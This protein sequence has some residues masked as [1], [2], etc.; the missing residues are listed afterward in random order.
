MMLSLRQIGRIW[1][2]LSFAAG[3]AAA[4]LWALSSAAWQSHLT[5]AYL[6]GHDLYA[7]LAQ[8]MTPPE[9]VAITPLSADDSARADAGDFDRITGAAQPAYVT[10]LS[11][12]AS[13]PRAPALSL[14]VVSDKLRYPVAPLTPAGPR[15]GEQLLGGLTRAM[16]SYC[17]QPVLFA[18]AGVGPWMRVEG[19]GVWVCDAAP[20]DLRLGAVA[21][22]VLALGALLPW[23]GALS[24]RFGAVA[25][26]LSR[27]RRA[28]RP[29]T[30][31]DR[32]PRELRQIVQ[33]VNETLADARAQLE[34]RALVL[35]G[36]SH[37]LGTPATRLRLRTAL[38]EDAALR[39]RFED[40]IDQMTG[41]IESVLTY[42]RSELAQEEPRPL[43]LSALVES[44]VD[45]FADTGARVAFRGCIPVRLEAPGTVFSARAGHGAW[46]APR[47]V[48]VNA[49][50]VA[51]TRAVSNL[52]DNALK[53]GRGA[54]V[55]IEP[56]AEAATIV[57]EDCAGPGTRA[58][59]IEALIEPFSRGA[60]AG[61]VKGFGLGL[62]IARAV[63]QQ[64]GGGLG[65]A[66][67]AQ[68]LQARL[69]I[70]R[71]DRVLTGL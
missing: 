3:V 20:R 16:A 43:S 19:P 51:L 62:T 66:D 10:H 13:P 47:R 42:T 58:A 55:W 44:V 69:Q 63:A 38:I 26:A 70:R 71:D 35:S 50:P 14:A 34:N 15:P 53:Y 2:V 61:P 54:Q 39:A 32:G 48:L 64:H 9:G 57:I 60:E 49:R 45:D 67:G 25:G 4:S 7:A 65:F 28:D 12:L 31:P 17:A 24:D 23:V 41:M 5:R 40:D 30:V 11:I 33:A 1:I 68:G 37:D 29:G 21:L 56:T 52:I 8:G 18:R 22:A 6:S 27:T 46:A 36:V 59:R